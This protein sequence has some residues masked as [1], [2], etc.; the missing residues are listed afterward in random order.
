MTQQNNLVIVMNMVALHSQYCPSIS[1]HR[2][3]ALARVQGHLD[4]GV[5]RVAKHQEVNLEHFKLLLLQ[6]V[7]QLSFHFVS[8]I[9]LA[10]TH[11]NCK[12]WGSFEKCRKFATR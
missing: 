8:V 4:I 11:H 10:S 3:Q 5:G 9:L 2:S 6:G 12:S 7:P 1:L